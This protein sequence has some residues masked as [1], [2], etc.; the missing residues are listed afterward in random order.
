M[1]SYYI[2]FF[3]YISAFLISIFQLTGVTMN[4]PSGLWDKSQLSREEALYS[5]KVS[6][7]RIHIERMNGLVF[8]IAFESDQFVPLHNTVNFG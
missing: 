6:S 8:L 1:I 5:R 2:A 3:L 7:L 4:M